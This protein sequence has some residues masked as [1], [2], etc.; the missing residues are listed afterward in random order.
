ML[1]TTFSDNKADDQTSNGPNMKF[2]KDNIRMAGEPVSIDGAIINGQPF[3]IE[4]GLVKTI[5]LKYPWQE[6]LT[7]PENVISQLRAANKRVDI[8]KFW[9]RIPDIEAKYPY[10]HEWHHPAAI[11]ISTHEKW[12]KSQLNKNARNKV[13]RSA[14][15]GLIVHQEQLTDELV[16][17]IMGIYNDSPLRRGKRFWHYGKDFETVKCELLDD[18]TETTYVTAYVE[19]ELIGFVK[20][21]FYDRYARTTL[22]LDKQSRRD[23][24]C[25]NS[26]I[27]KIVEICEDRKIPHFVYSFWRR[28]NHGQFQRSCGFEKHSVPYYYV[29]LSI[30]G[31]VTLMLNLHHGIR[32]WI[33]EKMMI[34]LLELRAKWYAKKYNTKAFQVGAK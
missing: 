32:G 31:K 6:D 28:G 11:P 26:M 18:S 27:S 8:L 17:K 10:Y 12:F 9:Q 34:Y 21:L 5:E 4:G 33:P 7:D 14:K 25:M 13:R 22:I 3:V 15:K 29:P 19:E 16:H 30:R 20:V 2:Y 24:G 23:I 1:S